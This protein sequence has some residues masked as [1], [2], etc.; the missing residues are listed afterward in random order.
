MTDPR[1]P[2]GRFAPPAVFTPAIHA[3]AIADLSALPTRLR[4]ALRG[5]SAAQLQTPYREG[6]WTS[7]QVV[8]HLVDSHMN[9]YIRLK[10]AL[11]EDGP[12]IRP[13]KEGAWAELP[14]ATSPDV[15]D[16]LALLG[17]LHVRFVTALA[18]LSPA[19]FP[20]PMIHPERGPTTIEKMVALY[21]WHGRHHVAH[22]TGLRERMGW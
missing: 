13:Y 9:A 1:Y 3:S 6:G 10:L 4:Q 21:A 8:H 2:I 12:T 11:T 18:H 14:D 15:E 5:L 20:R 22:I 16:S 7:A 19:D 17:A